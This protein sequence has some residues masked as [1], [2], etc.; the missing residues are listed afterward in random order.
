M[1]TLEQY[2]AAV[3]AQQSALKTACFIRR[4]TSA[5]ARRR[6]RAAQLVGSAML[7]AAAAPALA[8]LERDLPRAV[9]FE[10]YPHDS[11]WI[12]N[13]REMINRM[14]ERNIGFLKS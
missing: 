7:C 2:T 5:Q 3:C 12:L 10:S 11:D 1:P 14:I 4:L 9:T 13:T 6:L 8:F